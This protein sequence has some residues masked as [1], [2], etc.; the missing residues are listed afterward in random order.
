MRFICLVLIEYT[1]HDNE[2]VR[3]RIYP[4]TKRPVLLATKNAPVIPAQSPKVLRTLLNTLTSERKFC[5]EACALFC[6]FV[7]FTE[8]IVFKNA[9]IHPTTH[10]A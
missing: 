1:T 2:L 9:V 10:V 7:S 5:Q 8:V 3:K 6:Y 4:K